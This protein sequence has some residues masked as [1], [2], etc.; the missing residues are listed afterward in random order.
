MLKK[1]ITYKDL[2]DNDVTEDF[3]FNLNKAELIELELGKDGGLTGYMQAIVKSGN[4]GE[5]IILFKEILKSAYGKRSEDGRRFIK[6]DRL[7]D[8]F[9]QTE[10]YPILFMEV[11]TD[12]EKSAEFI[13]AIMPADLIA[14]AEAG[15]PA[16]P[17][18]NANQKV[19]SGKKRMS[20]EEILAGMRAKTKVLKQSDI[21]VMTQEEVDAALDAGATIEGL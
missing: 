9:V 13:K 10:A 19:A 12:A 15:E 17:N 8:E 7:W 21:L 18:E 5:I 11:V 2:D 1:T 16:F 20:R 14:K 3:Y 6:N 4:G